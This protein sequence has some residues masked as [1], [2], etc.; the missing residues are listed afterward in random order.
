MYIDSR[1]YDPNTTHIPQLVRGNN[2]PR[3]SETEAHQKKDLKNKKERNA[4]IKAVALT[5][6]TAAFFMAPVTLGIL[7]AGGVVVVIAI[8]ISLVGE[9]CLGGS[10]LFA[11]VNYSMLKQSCR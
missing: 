9:L 7:G 4:L 1:S 6:L 8:P 2:G 10:A 5:V 11:W 3:M